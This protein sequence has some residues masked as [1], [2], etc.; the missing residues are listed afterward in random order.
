MTE[1]RYTKNLFI[2]DVCLFSFQRAICCLSLR[3]DF[4]NIPFRHMLVNTFYFQK[5]DVQQR[6]LLI[7]QRIKK[8]ST[9][10]I[11]LFILFLISFALKAYS[12]SIPLEKLIF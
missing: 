10:F 4:I 9:Y 2:V 7:Y 5:V 8:S 11:N 6:R 12:I 1:V 3:G